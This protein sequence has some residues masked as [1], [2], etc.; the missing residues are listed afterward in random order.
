MSKASCEYLPS[1]ECNSGNALVIVLGGVPEMHVTRNDTMMFYIKRRRGFV[2]LAL[3]YGYVTK[4]D[5]PF[6]ELVFF[7]EEHPLCLLFHLE[8]MNFTNDELVL[9]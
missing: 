8:K 1:G 4:N 6:Q 5:Y 9:I 3:Q 2:R 7:P